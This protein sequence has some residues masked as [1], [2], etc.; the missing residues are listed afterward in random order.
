MVA[1]LSGFLLIGVIVAAGWGLRRWADLPANAE[2]V[3]A[4]VVWLVLNPCL[5]F[6]GVAGADLTALFSEPLLASAG[7]ALLCFAA[8]PVIVRNRQNR[9]IGALSGG[10][11]NANYIGIPIA[12]Y[13]LGDAALVVP[14]IMLQLLV[15]TPI[16]LTLLELAAT[17]RTSVRATLTTPLRNPMIV[18]VLLGA[19]VSLTGVRLPAMVLDPL[20]TVGH[21]A[22]PLVL[23][24]F[25]M[26]LSGRR[27]LAPGPDRAATV[28]AVLLKTV[29]MPLLAVLLATGLRLSADETYAVTVLACLPTAQ[30]VYL[31]GQRFGV[32]LVLARDTIFLTTIACV[33][34]VLLATL[35]FTLR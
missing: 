13:I 27:V 32:G 21:A 20:I 16:A 17:G 6:T 4:R 24:A 23:I 33:P 7:A 26:S 31:Y 14:I 3:L 1:A 11:V 28:V 10:Y 29:A 18:A 9:I 15:V 5:L 34:V 19:A 2:T 12:T 30:N 35:L 25:G 8:Y 22:V